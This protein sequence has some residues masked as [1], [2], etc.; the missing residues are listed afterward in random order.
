MTEW[1]LSGRLAPDGNGSLYGNDFAGA[2]AFMERK[3]ACI[4]AGCFGGTV[5]M[6]SA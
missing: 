4:L 6:G 3:D 2:D 1:H 5:N